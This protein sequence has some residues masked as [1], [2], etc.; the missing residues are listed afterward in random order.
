MIL[1]SEPD[2]D[3]ANIMEA[4]FEVINAAKQEVLIATPY[5]IPPESILTAL[6]TTAKSGVKVILLLPKYS[7]TL[8][9]QAASKTYIDEMLA[10]D[11]EVHLYERGMIHAKVIVV[12]NILVSLGT[13]NMDYR[14]FEYNAEVNAF[15]YNEKV[16]TRVRNQFMEDLAYSEKLDR[17]TWRKRPLK[18][19]LL[20]SVARIVAPLL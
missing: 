14:S 4:F 2:S 9:A 20:G 17:K 11:I 7:D 19:K 15:M 8:F 13:A 10:N 12:D 5:F 6:K 18:Q 3:N 1:N 16:A